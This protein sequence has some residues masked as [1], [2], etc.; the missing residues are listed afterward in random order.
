MQRAYFTSVL[1]EIWDP[2]DHK[3]C[4]DKCF[5]NIQIYF[6]DSKRVHEGVTVGVRT[7]CCYIYFLKIY[8]DKNASLRC[9]AWKIPSCLFT[10]LALIASTYIHSSH[11]LWE[12]FAI[13]SRSLP[14]YANSNWNRFS[15]ILNI[16]PQIVMRAHFHL[17]LSNDLSIQNFT[18]STFPVC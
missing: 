16:F 17:S 13:C 15:I 14:S 10:L 5:M 4:M 2:F 3:S 6:F 18:S 7:C 12:Q 11:R 1:V 9:Y 8:A